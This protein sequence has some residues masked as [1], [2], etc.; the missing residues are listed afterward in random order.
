MN[1]NPQPFIIK[2]KYTKIIFISDEAIG[3]VIGVDI[4]HMMA[5][6]GATILYQTDFTQPSNQQ[7]I[8]KLLGEQKADV[9]LSD[10][11]PNAT[12]IRNLDHEII[13]KLC[14]SALQ[15]A[16][17]VLRDGGHFMG[18]IWQGPDQEHLE[19]AMRTCFRSVRV[20]KPLSSRTDSAE[21]FLFGKGFS[22]QKR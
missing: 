10:M 14:F 9:V 21:I 15:F 5:V 7:R 20:V 17:T 13:V 22:R 16:T 12:G 19:T 1:L 18:K 6:D 11:A 3:R 8:I 4:Q 2:N